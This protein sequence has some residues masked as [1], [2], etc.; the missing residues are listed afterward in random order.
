MDLLTDDLVALRGALH[1]PRVP[2][3]A[4][5]D[6]A[7]SA[8]PG[9]AR[10]SQ[11]ALRRQATA[12]R[13]L[14][15]P[16]VPP[17]AKRVIHLYQAGGPSHL[18]LFDYKPKL[19]T[20][21]GEG[22]AGIVSLKGQPIAQ[23]QGRPLR[24]FGPQHSFQQ[25]GPV[26][27]GDLDAAAAPHRLHRGR[28]LHRAVHADRA[29]QPRSRP[30]VHEHGHADLGRPSAGSWIWYGHR[31]RGRGPARLRGPDF[32]G[33]RRADA[34]HR[35]AAMAQR[36]PAQPFPGVHFRSKGDASCTCAIPTASTREQQRDV[37]D[38]VTA[39]AKSQPDWVDDPR[40]RHG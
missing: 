26:G 18:E 39:L 3:G 33:P 16:H 35:G 38:A 14:P 32:A 25:R 36:L 34:A 6:G 5:R 10:R 17:R 29:D 8:G 23:L 20:M 15:T 13:R 27:T 28:D 9:R 11:A 7:R 37:I 40:S 1:A 31:R 12:A 24:C 22:H 4:A 30:H 19:G 21:D 2:L